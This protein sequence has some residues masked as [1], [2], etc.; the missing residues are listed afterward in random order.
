MSRYKAELLSPAR[1]VSF[2]K[3]NQHN[4]HRAIN[5][6]EDNT[7]PALPPSGGEGLGL[8]CLCESD[9]LRLWFLDSV[10]GQPVS[11][12]DI[13]FSDYI[14]SIEKSSRPQ[15]LLKTY[16][17]FRAISVTES[18]NE[19]K[20]I[21]SSG[22]LVMNSCLSNSVD[23][24]LHI[25]TISP[26]SGSILSY[27]SRLVD[28]II[29]RVVPIPNQNSNVA[30]GLLTK[31]HEDISFDIHNIPL[32]EN[33]ESLKLAT[34]IEPCTCISIVSHQNKDTL[35]CFGMTSKNK[36]YMGE[37]LIRSGI[38]SFAFNL[39]LGML[40]Y[41]TIGTKPKLH[42]CSLEAIE[43]LDPLMYENN[44][45]L[46]IECG[47]PRPLERGA[48]I[49]ASVEGLP[50]VIIQLPRGNLEAFEPRALVL[51]RAAKLLDSSDF[52]NCLVLL[53]RQ[54]V[55]LN[56]IVDY[57][58]QNFLDCIDLVICKPIQTKNDLL[59]LL[60]TSL[61]EYDSTC[62]KYLIPGL[63]KRVY[64]DQFLAEGKI[65]TICKALREELEKQTS[66]TSYIINPII[67]T[68]AKQRPPLIST[69]LTFIRSLSNNKD[70]A[71][72]ANETLRYLSFLVEPVLIFNTALGECDFTIARLIAKIS[73]MDPKIFN[74]LILSFESIRNLG[75][76]NDIIEPNFYHI[77]DS[78]MRYKIHIHLKNNIE[79]STWAIEA[80]FSSYDFTSSSDVN[81]SENIKKLTGL[82]N[83][84][85]NEELLSS[86]EQEVST[87]VSNS[88]I[89]DQILPDLTRR[90]LTIKKFDNKFTLILNNILY[91]VRNA[92]GKDCLDNMKYHDAVTAF[93]SM[94][95]PNAKEALRAARLLGD[96][97]RAII[98]NG[99][100][101]NTDGVSTKALVQEILS[102][103]RESLNQG[104]VDDFE[105]NFVDS[106]IPDTNESIYSSKDIEASRLCLEYLDDV[107]S[108]VD[109][110]LTSR[111]FIDA[112]QAALI[113]SR[114][115]LIEVEVLILYYYSYPY[116]SILFT[117]YYYYYY[118]YYYYI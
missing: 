102:D 67:C 118:H 4:Q 6:T 74:P 46:P 76:P 65:N 17:S 7:T 83:Q 107:E 117:Y 92:Y 13:D 11:H 108:A 109:I 54:K 77:Y 16:L 115:D 85:I 89:F 9:N 23:N 82:Q 24:H 98:I 95:P 94:T 5:S 8:A 20:L 70:H 39:E 25:F 73:Q 15:D 64:P 29:Y 93:L 69:A 114:Y 43:M 79:A 56:F 111:K 12:L 33:K 78:L 52:Y 40:L 2:W 86:L 112:I 81:S 57:N 42:F 66:V 14:M 88:K 31:S 19:I 106:T 38:N 21:I 1:Y 63:K 22:P 68:L 110:L 26:V 27:H 58:P 37:M 28:G 101:L 103:Y 10:N 41:V 90:Y 91:N 60:I 3:R 30:I 72:L 71:H 100:F 53:R 32:D 50:K 75:N 99:R 61:E 116:F 87:T 34:F 55:D 97:Q 48:R 80:L 59:S 36:L 51:N 47:L 18:D 96:W 35:M 113:K 84:I 44:Q 62:T 45:L 104:G 49:V 105:S